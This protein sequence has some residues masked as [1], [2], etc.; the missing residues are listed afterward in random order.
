MYSAIDAA[1]AAIDFAKGNVEDGVVN[2][3]PS[4]DATRLPVCLP[5]P[6][7]GYGSTST[8]QR[9]YSLTKGTLRT[10]QRQLYCKATLCDRDN[11]NG[12]SVGP[13]SKSRS[14]HSHVS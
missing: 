11:V 12:D 5:L 6:M 10:P 4:W 8:R 7:Q 1:S 3:P 2:S 13:P 14:S 9:S